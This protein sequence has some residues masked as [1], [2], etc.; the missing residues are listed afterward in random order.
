MISQH[1]LAHYK[2]KL[3]LDN[4]NDILK[5]FGFDKC[6][7]ESLCNYLDERLVTLFIE[8]QSHYKL[9]PR[10]WLNITYIPT[11]NAPA[12]FLDKI[13]SAIELLFSKEVG[14]RLLLKI[15]FAR[16]N[17]TIQHTADG[18]SRVGA[19]DDVR[20]QTVGCG[21]GSRILLSDKT[22]KVF[23]ANNTL[24]DMPFFIT[25]AHE[26]IHAYHNAYGKSRRTSKTCDRAIWSSDEEYHTITGLHAD[27]PD[28]KPRIT[29]NSIRKEHGLP[30][31]YGHQG[32]CDPL[33][34]AA[35]LP[36]DCG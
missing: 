12:D 27:V 30:L 28:R 7:K 29:E 5:L 31:R 17:V 10:I 16:H 18:S 23:D 15:A 8:A 21:T 20:G 25:L 34:L 19:I 33:N 24:I 35:F 9:P 22:L 26:L 1:F 11:K 3:E 32:F 4:T 14:R 36:H 6:I 2:Y 13:D